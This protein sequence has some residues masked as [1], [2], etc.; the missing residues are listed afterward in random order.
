[1]EA[2]LMQTNDCGGRKDDS[3]KEPFE[4]FPPRAMMELA[5]LYLAG[6]KKYSPRN[7][8]KGMRWGR[9]F[10][11]AMRHLWKFWMGEDVDAEDGIH[12]TIHAA[13]CCMTLFEYWKHRIGSD[14]RSLLGRSIG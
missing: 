8:E 3:D 12:H 9:V 4:L 6:S 11:A 1:M 13:W 14:D 7:W 10:A 5:R 2:T